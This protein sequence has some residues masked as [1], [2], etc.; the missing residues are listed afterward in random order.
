MIATV[1]QAVDG[2]LDTDD[3]NVVMRYRYATPFGGPDI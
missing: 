1:V 2:Q 3:D